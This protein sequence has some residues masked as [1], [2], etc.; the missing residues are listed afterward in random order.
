MLS[1]LA[2]TTAGFSPASRTDTARE[3]SPE[4]HAKTLEKHFAAAWGARRVTGRR[5]SRADPARASP[6]WHPACRLASFDEQAD[7]GG[8]RGGGELRAPGHDDVERPVGRVDAG[9]S[10]DQRRRRVG[11]PRRTYLVAVAARCSFQR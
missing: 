9:T 6:L 3:I 2:E 8:G 5:S 7:G 10:D 1:D 4:S 11:R